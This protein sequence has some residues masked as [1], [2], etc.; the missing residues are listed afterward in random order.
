MRAAVACLAVLACAGLGRADDPPKPKLAIELT[1]PKEVY[2]D[3]GVVVKATVCNVGRTDAYVVRAIDGS[4]DRYR[5]VVGY[6]WVVK[7]DGQVVPPKKQ[8][9]IIDYYTPSPLADADVVLV[10]GGKE[11]DMRVHVVGDIQEY[12][13]FNVPGKY[14]I[15][16]N[17][18]LHPDGTE[19]GSKEALKLIREQPAVQVESEA[20]EVTVLPWPA[21]VA[22][23]ADKVKLAE[24]KV[25]IVKKFAEGV[26]NNPNS[27]AADRDA[28]GE[29][30]KRAQ[31]ALD[32]ATAEH[33]TRLI[34]FNKKREEE[35][36]KK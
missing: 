12:Y 31:A 1:A 28:A 5:S 14:T 21:A 18:E 29:R 10:K 17:Y 26:V 34:E 35:R 23:A 20:V 4:F 27:T 15:K 22:A 6:W 3:E 9:V 24:A 30:L 33:V 7:K 11:A 19:K 2:P 36:K 13:R 8:S 25:Q 32:E 16:L